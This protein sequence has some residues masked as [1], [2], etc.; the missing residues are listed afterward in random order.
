MG[1]AAP[2]H[3]GAIMN[4]WDIR[5]L[6]SARQISS[7]SKDPTSKVGAVIARNKLEV[8]RGWNGFPSLIPDK[9]EYLNNREEKWKRM[10][11]AE[12]HAILQAKGDTQSTTIYTFPFFPCPRCVPLIHAAYIG[13]V[14]S[15]DI[16]REWDDESIALLKEGAVSIKRIPIGM[17][18]ED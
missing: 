18:D 5:H 9:Q 7:Y 8:S 14:V 2:P 12:V 10:L 17:L 1:S 11:H 13:R 16:P 6:Q 3:P 15:V 4:I